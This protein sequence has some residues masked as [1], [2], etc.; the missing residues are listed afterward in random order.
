MSFKN[1]IYLIFIF[2]SSTSAYPQ[3]QDFQFEHISIDQGLS[4]AGV[5]AILQDSRGFMWFATRDGLNKYDGYTITIYKHSQ[6][7]SLSLVDN[8]IRAIYEDRKGKLWIGTN[9]GLNRFDPITESFLTYKHDPKD[10]S[11]ISDNIVLSIYEDR[12]NRLWIGTLRGG[13]SLLDR[14][15]GTF[16]NYQHEPENP[17]SLSHNYLKDIYE[18]PDGALWLATLGG[19]LNQFDRK[20]GHFIRYKND[21]KNS[22]SISSNFVMCLYSDPRRSGK[23]WIG[24]Y[25]G[26][27]NQLDLQSKTFTHYKHDAEK[28]NTLSDNRIFDICSDPA[29]RLWLGTFAGGLNL[30][31]AEKNEFQSFRHHPQDAKSVSED[32]VRSVFV[33]QT[34]NLWAGTNLGGLNKL[35]IKPKKF[36]K[37]QHQTND[38]GSLRHNVVNAIYEGPDGTV[39]VGTNEGLDKLSP[40]ESSFQHIDLNL[41]DSQNEKVF[42]KTILVEGS[43]TV[44]IGTFGDGH[45]KYKP[46]TG[47]L[48]QFKTD[49]RNRN[50]I[51]DNRIKSLLQ[52]GAGTL[53]IGTIAGVNAFN[54]DTETFVLFANDPA[55]SN[56][57]SNNSVECLLSDQHGNIWIGTHDGLNKLEPHSRKITN[58][59]P[60]QNNPQSL[61]HKIVNALF[62]DS[63]GNLWVGTNN[64]L[65]RLNS[66][67]PKEEQFSHYFESDGLLSNYICGILEDELGNLWIS[68]N[69][70]ISRFNSKLPKGQQFRNYDRSDGLQGQ[71]LLVGAAYGAKSGEMFFGGNNGVVRFHPYEVQDN[72]YSPKVVLTAFNIFDQPSRLDTAISEIKEIQLSHKEN[73]FSLEFAALDYTQPQKNGYA[74]KMEGVNEDWVQAG[75][76]RYASYTNLDAGTYLFRVRGSNNDG[77]WNEEGTSLKIIIKPPFWQAWWVQILAFSAIVGLLVFAHKYRVTRLLE[78]ERTRNRIAQDLHDNVGATLSSISYFAQAIESESDMEKEPVLKKFLSLIRESSLEAQEAISDIIWSID[79]TNDRWEKV[80]AKFRRHA[81]DLFESKS[82]QYD[83]DIPESISVKKLDMERRRNFWLIFKEMTTNIARHSECSQAT[84]K[85]SAEDKQI[86]LLVEDDG[87]G[88][89]ANGDTS[90]NGIKNIRTR[91]NLLKAKVNLETTLGE[92]TSWQLRFGL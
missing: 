61:S 8:H 47:M 60:E 3:N 31:D 45:F 12:A 68:T 14:E 74:Y 10:S 53:W 34:G 37:Y 41:R 58:L 72:P 70:G 90:R 77:V 11:S 6:L 73:F 79:P 49:P 4:H 28:S 75:T 81:S 55:N 24:T 18:S 80:L 65:T 36:R 7:D 63:E 39:W 20:T 26:G 89:D 21:P 66:E 54:P 78:V 13:L 59:K 35:D 62:E 87:K 71:T 67:A 17:I 19:G 50:S 43:N 33:D 40:Q 52:D 23:L 29:G 56:S 32:F 92:G 64:G 42:V 86:H 16:K 51:A 48:K 44:W 84:I 25:G 76:R 9:L 38:P 85:L 57:L 91:A 30:F 46:S 88:F 83:I 82:I 1:F 15:Q 2:G 27:L 69:V 5:Q 22:Q